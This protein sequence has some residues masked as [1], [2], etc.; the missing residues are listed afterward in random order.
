MTSRLKRKLG[1][2]GVDTSS[3]RANE[4]FC[5]IGTPL[6]PLEKTKDINEFVPLWKQEVRD[7]KG[8][9]RLHGA[10]TGGFSAGYFNS[11]GS[12]EGWT[13]STFVSSK[14]DRAKKKASRPEDFMDEED[15]QELRDSRKLVDMTEEMDLTGG[16][17]AELQ[18]RNAIVNDEKDSVANALEATLLPA[19]KDS[20]GARVLRKMGWKPGQGIGP[21]I[22]YRER[23]L[24]DLQTTN[25]KMLTLAEVKVTEEE[26]EASKHTYPRRDTPVLLAERKDNFHGLGYIPKAGLL[27]SLARSNA[28]TSIGPKLSAGF[29][30]GALNDAED[31]DID[32]YDNGY[33][34][35][36]SRLAYDISQPE[37]DAF[38]I[39]KSSRRQDAG[40]GRRPNAARAMF[41]SGLPV[42]PGF[43]ISETP[44]VEDKW[45]PGPEVPKGWTPNPKRVWDADANKENIESGVRKSEPMPY[46]KW[47]TGMTADQRGELLGETPLPAAP[48]S[49][50]EYMSQKDRERLQSVSVSI[51][52]G[53]IPTATPPEIRLPCIEPQIAQA[54]LRGFQPFTSDLKKQE[55]YTAYLMSQADPD[56]KPP[57][58]LKPLPGQRIDEFNKE[59]E[60]YSKAANIFKPMSGLMAGRFTSAVVMEQGPKIHEGLHTP[61]S[62]EI[63]RKEAAE[64]REEEKISPQQHAAKLGMYGAMT[65]EVR[66]W[67]PARLLCKRFGVKEPDLPLPDAEEA[68]TKAKADADAGQSWQEQ[69]GVSVSNS[70]ETPAAMEGET[71]KKPDLNNIGLGEDDSQGRDTLTYQRPSMDIFK[72]IFASDLEDSDDDGDD[73]LRKDD[74]DDTKN[75]EE[76]SQKDD[77]TS[78]LFPDT[79]LKMDEGASIDLNTFKPTFIPRDKKS[80]RAKDVDGDGDEK[81]GE[82]KKNGKKNKD[83]KD[84]KKRKKDKEKKGVLVSFEMEE[85]GVCG[86]AVSAAKPKKDRKSR[87]DDSAGGEDKDRPKKKKRKEK[88]REDGEDDGMWE[89]KTQT[90]ATMSQLPPSEVPPPPPLLLRSSTSV[91]S[92][93]DVEQRAQEIETPARA[94]KRAI[95]FM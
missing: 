86:L 37:D 77:M 51:A 2:L 43:V 61:S 10:F 24:Q 36:K 57:D 58:L 56:S 68:S 32:I 6:P 54:A 55:R 48:R 88:K 82:D 25:K 46:H 5:L 67:Q 19:P 87:N 52:S 16:T 83:K 90:A 3:N 12:K 15:L 63:E 65:R 34:P 69:A 21:R 59:L 79:S 92:E 31:D 23:K 17:Q 66:P 38:T 70:T 93:N 45:Y 40:T 75:G 20:A 9:R 74:E 72:A 81:K 73:D 28:E 50:F 49:V 18:Q 33:N 62:E 95:D 94:R 1:E 7:E 60:D 27:D 26:E 53:S 22:S 8:R 4:N 89:A 71:S 84:K 35:G 78:K 13:P 41:S 76:E 44:A 85:D 91:S 64:K 30:L 11:V 14:S 42:L 80:K 47:K 39:H 29:G